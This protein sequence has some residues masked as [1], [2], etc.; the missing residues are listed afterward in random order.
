MKKLLFLKLG[1]YFSPDE[2]PNKVR[3]TRLSEYFEGDIMAVVNTKELRN[4]NI[5]NFKLRGLYLPLRIRHKTFL[6]DV[7]YALFAITKSIYSHYFEAKYDAIITY[8]PFI[9]GPLAI[10]IG[11]LTRTKTIIEINGNYASEVNWELN[12]RSFS[13][14]LKYKYCLYCIP[15]VVNHAN[16]IKLLYSD[17]IKPFQDK[18]RPTSKI[19]C[20]HNLVPI[21]QIKAGETSHKYIL[22]L[23]TPWYRKGV[24][25]LIKAYNN[26]S[27]EFPDYILKIVGY[28]P[29]KSTLINLIDGNKH[30]ELCEPVFHDEA[31]KLLSEC[32]L[33]V[34]PS[35]SEAMG[36]VLLEAMASKKPIIASN[37][38]GIP[39]YIKH[40]YN[41]LLFQSENVDDLALKIKKVLNDKEYANQLAENGYQ[42]V[43]STLSEECYLKKF[44][45]VIEKVLTD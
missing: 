22:F 25:V 36:R 19:Y 2:L 38:D 37:V 27:S 39:T 26:I 3:Y 35:R 7:A 28:F 14:L 20:F 45:E 41:G 16:A 42:Y 44:S 15:L 9:T 29:D 4:S 34:L 10:V 17:Q 8:D 31:M 6:R 30:I 32:C 40:G 13:S 23:G 33:F 24:D 21:S 18:I 43:N 11:K 5:G 1:P 12:R